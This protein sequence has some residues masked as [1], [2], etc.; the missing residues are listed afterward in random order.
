[1]LSP[2]RFL[3]HFIKFHNVPTTGTPQVFC[4][5]KG[6]VD[7]VNSTSQHPDHFPNISLA[8]DWD[9]VHEIVE[10]M[11]QL[12]HPPTI[13]HIKGHQDRTKSNEQL[14]LPA[15]LNVDADA[16]ADSYMTHHHDQHRKAP[17]LPQSGCLL[18]LPEGTITNQLQQL[19][20]I[21]TTLSIRS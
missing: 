6:L 5:N 20:S 16:L 18:H 12:T 3:I 2:L 19:K 17:L 13:T 7:N 10:S 21:L 9:V 1:M 8:A 14:S 4:D 11:R 15:Q